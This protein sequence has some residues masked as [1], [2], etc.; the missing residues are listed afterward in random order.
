MWCASSYARKGMPPSLPLLICGG[1]GRSVHVSSSSR[2]A[3]RMRRLPLVRR[4]HLLRALRDHHHGAAGAGNML[5]GHAVRAA[6]NPVAAAQVVLAVRRGHERTDRVLR[7]ARSAARERVLSTTTRP[8]RSSP[9]WLEPHQ[10]QCPP[11]TRTSPPPSTQPSGALSTRH[12]LTAVLRLG[13]ARRLVGRSS[14]PRAWTRRG[15]GGPSD[16]ATRC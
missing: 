4:E 9:S 11:F 10:I 1:A 8:R 12:E 5:P 6:E 13:D 2:L 14:T 15:A 16:P 3:D 7:L